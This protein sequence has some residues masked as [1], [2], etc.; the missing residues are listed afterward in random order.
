MSTITQID[1][2]IK[3]ALKSGQKEKLTVL[4]GLKSDLKYAQIDK[5]KEL[6]EED[7][8][9]VLSSAAKKRR[10]SIEQFQAGGRQDLVDSETFGLNIIEQYLPK[11]LSEDE[12]RQ[13]IKDAVAESGAESPQ[14][15]GLVMK[16]VMPKV[17]GKADGKVVN[18]IVSEILAN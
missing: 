12:L 18:R 9:G 7:V 4:R 13:I 14:Q 6:T 1:S 8:I 17:K 2:D 5:G 11:Q 16:V 10:D 15:I 3:E